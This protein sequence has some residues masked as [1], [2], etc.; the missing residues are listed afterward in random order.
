MLS[1]RISSYECTRERLASIRSVSASFLISAALA[2]ISMTRQHTAKSTNYL[3]LHFWIMMHQPHSQS[4]SSYITAAWSERGRNKVLGF[5]LFLLWCTLL[6]PSLKNNTLTSISR[7][8]LDW[9][10]YCFSGTICDVITSPHLHNKN[11]N[12]SKLKRKKHI[13][14]FHMTSP[15]FKLQNHWSSWYILLSCCIRAAEN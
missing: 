6:V 5:S 3:F 9:V 8:I 2:S 10:L 4:L 7:D 11:L 13:A 12:V 1:L 15:K 14:G